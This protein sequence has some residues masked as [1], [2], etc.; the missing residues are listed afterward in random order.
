MFVISIIKKLKK[1]A[2]IQRALLIY[3]KIMSPPVLF[4]NSF[5][6]DLSIESLR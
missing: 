6:K 3:S 4:V 1:G 2:R 5:T